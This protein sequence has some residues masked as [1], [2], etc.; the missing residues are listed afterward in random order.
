MLAHSLAGWLAASCPPQVGRKNEARKLMNDII[1]KQ[2]GYADMRV[3][4]AAIQFN[5]GDAQAAEAN[6]QF[7]CDK[8][9]VG[10]TQYK[11]MQW[12]RGIR[13]WPP[14]LADLL[15]QFLNER[16]PAALSKYASTS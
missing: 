15:E 14:T 7:T 9:S 8:I 6:W 13:R 10:C 2:P 11:D 4:L 1:R 5:E 3:A 16:V 12:V